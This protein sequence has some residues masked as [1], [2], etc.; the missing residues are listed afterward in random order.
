LGIPHPYLSSILIPISHEPVFDADVC[1]RQLCGDLVKVTQLQPSPSGVQGSEVVDTTLTTPASKRMQAD[2]LLL[3]ALYADPL[4]SQKHLNRQHCLSRRLRAH[5]ASANKACTYGPYINTA[6][7]V[8]LCLYRA[9]L[10]VQMGQSSL[11]LASAIMYV[12]SQTAAAA[13]RQ[14]CT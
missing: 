6:A 2:C 4:C 5:W 8:L 12:F 9:C 13:L 7:A 11:T 3:V 1:N 14:C 10:R